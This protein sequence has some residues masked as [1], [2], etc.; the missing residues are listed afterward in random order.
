MNEQIKAQIRE[1]ASTL[2]VGQC[3][4]LAV[5]RCNDQV[6]KQKSTEEGRKV[7]KEVDGKRIPQYQIQFG[8]IIDTGKNNGLSALQLTM[9]GD[10]RFKKGARRSW[11]LTNV[12]Q[13][14][15]MAQN[16][17]ITLKQEQFDSLQVGNGF[18]VGA[19]N[20]HLMMGDTKV[21]FGLQIVET[22]EMNN[23]QAQNP[24]NECKR[25]GKDGPIIYGD[26]NGTKAMIFSNVEAQIERVNTNT[27]EVTKN[28]EHILIPEFKEAET[29]VKA[30]STSEKEFEDILDQRL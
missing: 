2:D 5:Q 3:A 19:K 30:D 8:E 21:N 24:D 15:Q 29:Y 22:F 18:F 20:P 9:L 23:Y 6:D 14:M 1:F 27:G 28:W 16:S 4:M 26:N 11:L 10:S 25:A 17:G 13:A 7:Y 12:K